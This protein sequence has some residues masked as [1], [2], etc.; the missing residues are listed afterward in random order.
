MAVEPLRRSWRRPLVI[1]ILGTQTGAPCPGQHLLRRRQPRPGFGRCV[2][3]QRRGGACWMSCGSWAKRW[4]VGPV[5]SCWVSCWLGAHVADTVLRVGGAF[6]PSPVCCFFPAYWRRLAARS[7]RS[8]LAGDGGGV[9]A[10]LRGR[11][12]WLF[13]RSC[14]PALRVPGRCGVLAGNTCLARPN[15]ASVPSTN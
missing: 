6:K 10:A 2:C 8:R 9:S 13:P 7:R 14:P 15:A 11:H 3:P 4:D 5:G 12:R 1:V